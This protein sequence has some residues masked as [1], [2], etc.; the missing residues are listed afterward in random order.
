MHR[1]AWVCD[2]L[3]KVIIIVLALK[4]FWNGEKINGGYYVSDHVHVYNVIL[5]QKS[6][7]FRYKKTKPCYLTRLNLYHRFYLELIKNLMLFADLIHLLVTALDWYS[8]QHY[9]Q[10]QDE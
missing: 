3:I 10:T 4:S 2:S 7:G 1:L 8:F 6:V 5:R 9:P